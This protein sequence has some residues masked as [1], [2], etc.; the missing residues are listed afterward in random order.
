MYAMGVT[1]IDDKILNKAAAEK[2]TPAE[3]AKKFEERFFEDMGRLG[4]LE[5]HVRLRVSEHISEIIAYIDEIIRKGYA[6]SA[7]SGVY[8]DVKKFG[9]EHY[10]NFGRA[11]SGDDSAPQQGPEASEKRDARDFALW[12]T[13][14]SA[15]E[16]WASPWGRGRPGWH[17]ECSAL[18]HTHFGPD[19]Q[20]HSGSALKARECFRVLL[21]LRV[22]SGF[23][24]V[25]CA[26]GCPARRLPLLPNR[27]RRS[28]VAALCTVHPCGG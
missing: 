6:Y 18:T 2:T 19:F 1:D 24:G 25:A 22:L 7:P 23:V 27:L 20:V 16:G 3:I 26:F 8:F 28:R 14:K 21:A 11:I 15:D 12:K 13:A 4:V 9:P 17:I 5:P 10:G